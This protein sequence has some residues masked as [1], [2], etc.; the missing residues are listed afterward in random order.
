MTQAGFEFLDHTADV[1][2]RATGASLSELFVHAARGLV[3]LLAEDSAA[4]PAETRSVTITAESVEDLLSAWLTDVL[5]WFD[6]ERF[7]PA[8]FRLDVV[9]DTVLRGQVD[10]ERFDPERHVSG[11]EVKGVTRHQFLVGRTPD[12][13]WEARIIFDV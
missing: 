13:G 8:A 2:L 6:A 3:A 10:G 1:G 4:A 5:V 9:T 11:V 7:L 12:G